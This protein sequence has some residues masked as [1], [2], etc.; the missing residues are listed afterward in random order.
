MKQQDNNGL[1]IPS[2]PSITDDTEGKETR[3]KAIKKML[4]S[5]RSDK[6]AKEIKDYVKYGKTPVINSVTIGKA[7][8]ASEL[9]IPDFDY[10]SDVDKKYMKDINPSEREE[11]KEEKEKVIRNTPEVETPE[12]IEEKIEIIDTTVDSSNKNELKAEDIYT[13][14]FNVI[15]KLYSST[16]SLLS[17]FPFTKTIEDLG[18]AASKIEKIDITKL[19]SNFKPKRDLNAQLFNPYRFHILEKIINNSYKDLEQPILYLDITTGLA[20]IPTGIDKKKTHFVVF[21]DKT[22]K[23]YNNSVFILL[24]KKYRSEILA[25]LKKHRAINEASINEIKQSIKKINILEIECDNA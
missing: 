14:T 4:K 1:P 20:S 5:A 6:E 10:L 12:V 16:R 18:I 13:L 7:P 3:D 24:S 17:N 15:H 9:M 25:I 21:K 19:I 23:A 8:D 22:T 2:F 11:E